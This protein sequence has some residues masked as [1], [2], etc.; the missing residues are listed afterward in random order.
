MSPTDT[1][2][3]ILFEDCISLGASLYCPSFV[4]ITENQSWFILGGQ[5]C[6]VTSPLG[7]GLETMSHDIHSDGSG[8]QGED[9][10]AREG[11][12]RYV[13]RE[14]P[15]EAEESAEGTRRR[16]VLHGIGAF[17]A[18][19]GLS[20]LDFGDEDDEPAFD[21]EW[22][23]DWERVEPITGEDISILYA[24]T[25]LLDG[26]NIGEVDLG[27]FGSI[28]VGKIAAKP[29][30][31][32]RA[33]EYGKA[34]DE[35]NYDVVMMCENFRSEDRN[36]I[37]NLIGDLSDRFDGPKS[38]PIGPLDIPSKH[39]GLH[40]FTM[41]DN[42]ILDRA[43]EGFEEQGNFL[44]D[45]DYY[46]NKGV[47]YIEVDVGVG[48]IDLF[49][50]HMISGGGLLSPGDIPFVNPTPAPEFRAAQIKQMRD[51][52]L[53]HQKSENITVVTGDFN[54]NAENPDH[55]HGEDLYTTLTD[56]MG[57]ADLYDAWVEHGGSVG[58]TFIKGHPGLER[59]RVHPEKP[60]YFD[61]TGEYRDYPDIDDRR[62]DYV[63][64]QEEQPSHSFEIEVESLRRRHFWREIAG[65]LLFWAEPEEVPNYLSDHIALELNLSA[66]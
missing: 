48:T 47:H 57:E 18:G 12:D 31:D 50:T 40:S 32:Q 1:P 22:E 5:S 28:D 26:L 61:D 19:L 44:R 62:I 29:Q 7:G 27:W 9:Q 2:S 41:G 16:E 35:S 54:V 4:L 51:F 64:I 53:E 42:T 52:I 37:E 8:E 3:G 14:Q 59:G 66:Y 13:A 55:A 25:W 56:A 30:L 46:A 58:T 15:M 6:M 17:G 60:K 45:A 63:F 20:R 11:S 43:A 10:P 49:T 38:A 34:L 65:A 36:R 39:S 33:E 21:W 24:N 23:R